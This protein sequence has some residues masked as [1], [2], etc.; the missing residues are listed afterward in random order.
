MQDG[1]DTD[2][3]LRDDLRIVLQDLLE[4]EA[5]RL[6]LTLLHCPLLLVHGH[7]GGPVARRHAVCRWSFGTEVSLVLLR[8]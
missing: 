1:K 4:R 7:L 3:H 8:L 2:E 6:E 5:L